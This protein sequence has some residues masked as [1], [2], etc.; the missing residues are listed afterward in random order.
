[1]PAS[2]WLSGIARWV[3]SP[4]MSDVRWSGR[5]WLPGEPDTTV[6]GWLDLSGRWP[7]LELA[8][9]LT[10][11]MRVVSRAVAADG[12]V[13][14]RSQPADD[15]LRPEDLTVHGMLRGNSRRRVTLVGATSAGRK[16]VF[17]GPVLD[18]GDQMLQP[19]YVLLGGHESGR[20]ALFTRVR[21][22]LRHLD[23]WAQLGGVEVRVV[24]DG[25][26]VSVLYDRQ[27]AETADVPGQAAQVVLDSL[28]GIPDPT[29][30]GAAV[31]QAAELRIEVPNEMTLDRLWRRFVS[32]LA[33]LLTLVVDAP[34]PPVALSVYSEQDGRWL[35]VRRPE[36]REP[37]DDLLP[38]HKVLLTRPDLDVGHLA[39][40]LGAAAQL[41][42]IPSLVAEVATAPDRTLA[43]QL[44]DMAIAAEGL[45]RRLRPNE[46]MMSR[47]QAKSTRQQA[48]EAIA[49]HGLRERVSQALAHLEE[50][51]YAERLH[52]LTQL[53]EQAVPGATGDTAE[54]E[55][56]IKKVRNGF[57]HQT[58]PAAHD[59]DD[60]E[61][62]EYLILLRTLRWVLTGVLLL[63]TGLDAERLR[64]RLQQ[65]E[66]YRFLL[67]QAREWLP[68]L[69]PGPPPP[70]SAGS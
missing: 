26:H 70:G 16:T 57:A 22:Q 10:P 24:Q 38:V 8:E 61:W 5:F 68:N 50:P 69:Y 36:L 47:G 17:S 34:C 1:M 39:A 11:G 42:P 29:V 48:R 37:A 43:N 3:V 27:E 13:S 52:F 51:T 54:W 14:I 46:R 18:P 33:V 21:L 7:R 49:D 41:R 45:H 59:E 56:R 67:R 53:C 55:G 2:W 31:T 58:V 40:W 35:E 19:A 64:G 32:P 9:P 66:P 23:A 65:H 6:G 63:H 15:P 4:G 20:D 28:V 25:S 30:Q 12:S 44:L 62:Q 60:A